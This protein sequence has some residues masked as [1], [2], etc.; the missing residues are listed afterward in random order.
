M[1]KYMYII[2]S[3]VSLYLLKRVVHGADVVHSLPDGANE[4]ASKFSPVTLY[5]ECHLIAHASLRKS[6]RGEIRVHS[7]SYQCS[8][9]LPLFR[10]HLGDEIKA[11]VFPSVPF[12]KSQ[13]TYPS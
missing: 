11:L 7:Y 9:S 5:T 13:T 6:P 8:L 10:S 2:Y 4:R 12:T 3:F 1:Y